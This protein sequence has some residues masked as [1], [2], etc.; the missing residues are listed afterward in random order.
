M[1]LFGFLSCDL[2]DSMPVFDKFLSLDGAIPVLGGGKNNFVYVPGTRKDRVLLVAHADTV[3]DK[4]YSS[5]PW[6]AYFEEKNM[7]HRIHRISIDGN[8]IRRIGCLGNRRRRQGRLCNAV[9]AQKKRTFPL[10]DRR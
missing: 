9:A 7:M 10:G 1:I 5:D 2:E 8:I 3:W 4:Y 6:K